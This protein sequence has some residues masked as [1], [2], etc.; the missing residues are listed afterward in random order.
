MNNGPGHPELHELN[1]EGIKVVY[2]PSNIKFLIQYPDHRIIKTLKAHYTEYFMESTVTTMEENPDR[3]NI[4]KVW[5]D[6]IIGDANVVIEKTVKAIK[7]KTINSAGENCVQM[8]CMTPQDLRQS[9]SRKSWKRLWVWQKKFGGGGE[10]FQDMN[11]GE[12]RDLVDTTPEELTD[13][14]M[15]MSASKSLPD[16]EDVEEAVPETNWH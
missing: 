10:G 14:L 1:T 15:E 8:L 12:I 6:Y 11:F 3:E 7:P 5:K 4:M 13:N 16:N 9:K 2:F